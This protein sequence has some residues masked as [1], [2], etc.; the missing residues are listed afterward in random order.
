MA[1]SI[2]STDTT[3]TEFFAL[4]ELEDQFVF[5]ATQLAAAQAAYNTANP[6]APKNAISVTPDYSNARITIQCVLPLASNAV[7]KF[8]VSSVTSVF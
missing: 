8:D 2:K 3:A 1:A 7:A 4:T 6:T 5:V